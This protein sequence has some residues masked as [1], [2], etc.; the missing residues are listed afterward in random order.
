MLGV[1]DVHEKYSLHICHILALKQLLILL[2]KQPQQLW[3]LHEPNQIVVL[4]GYLSWDADLVAVEVVG[5]L[6]VSIREI[7]YIRAAHSTS[8]LKVF[9]GTAFSTYFIR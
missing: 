2:W 4:I 9:L 6:A 3:E 7:A 1:M 8:G 5:L